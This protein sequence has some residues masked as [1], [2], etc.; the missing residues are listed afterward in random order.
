MAFV[1]THFQVPSAFQELYLLIKKVYSYPV[2]LLR[3]RS[4]ILGVETWWTQ[5]IWHL[6]GWELRFSLH[7]WE[8]VWLKYI[9]CMCKSA[10]RKSINLCSQAVIKNSG[11]RQGSGYFGIHIH[12]LS[13]HFHLSSSVSPSQASISIQREPQEWHVM[14]KATVQQRMCGN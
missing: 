13:S 2:F 8:R 11:Q 4:L 12:Q 5:S 6:A 10:K 9:M 14:R 1:A 3:M 7:Y